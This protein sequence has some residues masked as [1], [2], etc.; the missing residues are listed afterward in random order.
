MASPELS[1]VYAA[2]ILD[3]DGMEITADKLNS[4]LSAAGVQVESYWVDLFSEYFKNHSISDLIKATSLGGAPSAAAAAPVAGEAQEEKK[5]EKKEEEEV[6]MA[7]GFDD[8]FD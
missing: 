2:L 3:D 8:L 6:A 7:G 4:L 1:I 5:E